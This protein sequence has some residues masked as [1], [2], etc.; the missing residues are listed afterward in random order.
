MYYTNLIKPTSIAAVISTSLSQVSKWL[1][2]LYKAMMPMVNVWWVTELQ[3]AKVPI[4]TVCSSGPLA[5]RWSH[6][7]ES[8][9]NGEMSPLFLFEFF[10]FSTYS[11]KINLSNLR[12]RMKVLANQVLIGCQSPIISAS[13]FRG[14][15][16]DLKTFGWRILDR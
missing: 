12:A 14:H 4:E 5:S 7:L 16:F 11:T 15:S 2:S 8:L 6:A 10:E 1:S 13:G 9:K 3:E